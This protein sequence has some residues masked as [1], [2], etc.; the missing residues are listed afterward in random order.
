MDGSFKGWGSG[1][2]GVIIFSGS[3]PATRLAVA[4]FDPLFLTSARAALA[5]VLAVALLAA[6]K[7]TRRARPT[8]ADIWPLLIVGLGVVL[9]YPL[10]SALA[11]QH[12]GSAH[13]IVFLGLLPLATAMFGVVYGGER[14]K[15]P[16]WVFSSIGGL[17]VAAF[18]LSQGGSRSRI[19]DLLML[20]GIL[21][22][23]LGYG[24]GAVLWC[25]FFVCEVI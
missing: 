16:F 5:G 18:A 15:A 13:S 12:M 14:P 9:G 2:L 20:A 11:L 1:L 24:G 7:Q 21:L 3:L 10:L 23:G 8:R 25:C 19:G 17:S 22:C 4:D 6:T